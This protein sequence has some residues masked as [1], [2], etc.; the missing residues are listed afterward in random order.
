[1]ANMDQSY[2]IEL[3]TNLSPTV[4][5]KQLMLRFQSY[6]ICKAAKPLRMNDPVEN[7]EEGEEGGG[8]AEFIDGEIEDIFNSMQTKRRLA[9]KFKWRRSKCSYYCPVS[10]KDGRIVTGKAEFGASFLDKIYLMADEHSLKEFLKN[11]RPYL[12]LPQPR[13]PC[14]LSI[15]G[16]RFSG[17]TTLCSA[18]AKKY[19][20]KVIDMNLLI[21]PEQKRYKE[22]LIEKTRHDTTHA[23]IEQI[24]VKFHEA[25][26]KE[27]LRKDQEQADRAAA[28]EAQLEAQEGQEE[29]D[30]E[31]PAMPA[32]APPPPPTT[33][34]KP[35]EEFLLSIDKHVRM[36]E[37]GEVIV[38]NDH[39][40][41]IKA[42]TK[43]VE[44]ASKSTIDISPS[45]YV[46]I[47]LS[48]IEKVRKER[49]K[50]DPLAPS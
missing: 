17:K 38:S 14:K 10:L 39:P 16:P 27:R 21:E 30:G 26:E 50:H 15:L 18:L 29:A 9:A 31:V 35:S 8:S 19:N 5:L 12:R 6:P 47:L 40:D 37:D 23:V 3:D 33:D 41:I 28:A 32:L 42:V 2:L 11:P 48:E 45:D 36:S 43:A 4:L 22:E 34:S 25:L 7:G 1:M 20:A 49:A 44:E 46:K 13:A 24:K